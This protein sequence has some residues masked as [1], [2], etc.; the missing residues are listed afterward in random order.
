MLIDKHRAQE[1][2]HYETNQTPND[3]LT[4]SGRGQITP[5]EAST[6]ILSEPDDIPASVIIHWPPTPTKINPRR[7]RDT[8]AAV[9]R[10]FSEA[11]IALA[12]IKA[13]GGC[14]RR[15]VLAATALS[16]PL[17]SCKEAGGTG[18]WLRTCAYESGVALPPATRSTP[19]LPAGTL[20]AAILHIPPT[21]IRGHSP[22]GRSV[23]RARP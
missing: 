18:G 9:A 4:E 5:T 3:K 14:E 12:R 10:M 19:S 11:H 15:S 22:L 16:A 7:F 13:G 2:R 23:R 1:S 17:A 21:G 8:A 20:L 6:I